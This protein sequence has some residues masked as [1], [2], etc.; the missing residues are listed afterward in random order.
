MTELKI[1]TFYLKIR[2]TPAYFYKNLFCYIIFFEVTNT[3]A[4]YMG[5]SMKKPF[6]IE[7]DLHLKTLQLILTKCVVALCF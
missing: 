7:L 5:L 4:Y 2:N 6:Y 3:L 1:L